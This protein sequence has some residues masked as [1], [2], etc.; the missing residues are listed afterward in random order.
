M[1]KAEMYVPVCGQGRTQFTWRSRLAAR[2]AFIVSQ[3]YK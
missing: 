1:T 3:L 2:E